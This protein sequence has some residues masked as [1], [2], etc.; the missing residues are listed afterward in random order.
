MQHC[1]IL[2]H[3]LLYL[4]RSWYISQEKW[5]DSEFPCF[6]RL[7]IVLFECYF[8]PLLNMKKPK[9][10]LHQ[11][12]AMDLALPDPQLLF[13]LCMFHADIIQV[14]SALP[15][16]NCFSINW[17]KEHPLR[18]YATLKVGKFE[19]LFYNL[20]RYFQKTIT[21]LGL[22][23]E[24][25]SL[26]IFNIYNFCNFGYGFWALFLCYFQK[27]HFLVIRNFEIIFAALYF[28]LCELKRCVS[29]F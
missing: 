11:G 17:S 1:E 3:V 9:H 25:Y 19:F 29:D 6:F 13:A 20:I 22:Q 16:S 4:A 5:V 12:S 23:E 7:L 8:K 21:C 28:Y 2:L 27:L 18:Y 10:F 15:M 24:Q 14:S 26:L